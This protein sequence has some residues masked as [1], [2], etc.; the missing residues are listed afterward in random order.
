[1]SVVRLEPFGGE[2]EPGG[3]TVGNTLILPLPAK[4][5]KPQVTRVLHRSNGISPDVR[6]SQ[7]R[8][9]RDTWPSCRP[10]CAR[11]H[12][13]DTSTCRRCLEPCPQ[14]PSGRAKEEL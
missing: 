13:S 1:M 9:E 3:L 11:S 14:S 4:Q 5:R 7:S 6:R 10:S 12:G 8:E 2:G